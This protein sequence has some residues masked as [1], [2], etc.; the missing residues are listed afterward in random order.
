MGST[1]KKVWLD[2]I[3]NISHVKPKKASTAAVATQAQPVA[4]DAVIKLDQWQPDWAKPNR[5]NLAVNTSNL[6]TLREGSD[7]SFN[8]SWRG[9]VGV[10]ASMVEKQIKTAVSSQYSVTFGNVFAQF[11]L[12]PGREIAL[13]SLLLGIWLAIFY[14]CCCR[15]TRQKQTANGRRSRLS[16]LAR[17]R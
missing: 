7:A 5:T 17:W 16:R 11:T 9:S 15:K 14:L 4:V 3:N 13:P 1:F 10:Q 12:R 6:E 2:K 8:S